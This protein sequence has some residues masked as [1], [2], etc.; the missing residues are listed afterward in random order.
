MKAVSSILQKVSTYQTSRCYNPEL[1]NMDAGNL[2]DLR[3][4]RRK[5]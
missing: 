5:R 4:Y 1:D 2:T 3:P